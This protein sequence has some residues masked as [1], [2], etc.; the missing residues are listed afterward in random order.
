ML[1]AVF[2]GWVDTIGGNK[3]LL[4]GVEGRVFLDFGV[5]FNARSKYF[6]TFLQPRRFSYIADYIL[7]DVVPPL[8]GLY[9]ED[10]LGPAA[11]KFFSPTP[12]IEAVILSHAH[13]DHYGH[14]GLLRDDIPVHMGEG[15]AVLVKAREEVRPQ[16]LETLFN[17]NRR[18]N[19][20]RTGDTFEVAGIKFHPTHVD[21]SIP[22]AYGFIFEDEEGVAAYTG[23]LRDHGPR[24]DMTEDFVQSCVEK[25]VETLIIEGTRLEESETVSEKAVG[26]KI[27]EI[28]SRAEG[29]LVAVVVGML[30]FDRLNTVI[31]ASIEAGRMPAVSLH[32]A[33][34]LRS[35][36][37]K[38]LRIDVPKLAED[39]LVAYLEKRRSG[40]Y[41]DKDYPGWMAEL[42]DIVPTVRE[43]EVKKD[44][45]RYVLVLSKAEDVI[46]LAGMGPDPGS[47]F[48]ISTSEPHSEEQQ[49][50]MDKIENW[51]RLLNLEMLHVHASG[52]ASGPKLLNMISRINPKKV[53]PVHTEKPGLYRKM[54]EETLPGASVLLP[55][56]GH[57][58]NLL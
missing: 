16:S 29:K 19:T 48:I 4:E 33:H 10:L 26:A 50:E 34:V 31:S 42:I 43:E 23:D 45:D 47:P 51:A 39:R 18:V 5:D 20:F 6:S 41:S 17:Q 2:Y 44:K 7:T 35:L 3:I 46:D 11:T 21:H 53:I 36:D 12:S 40:T 58:V 52:H 25:G 55:V 54:V 49:I 56:K 37:G 30:D 28:I 38:G 13:T 14:A 27:G 24:S 22:A 32:H 9:R 8:K 1:R 15:A 57:A